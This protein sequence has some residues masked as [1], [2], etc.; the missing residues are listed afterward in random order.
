M[1]PVVSGTWRHPLVSMYSV[2]AAA[3][4]LV[5]VVSLVGIGALALTLPG[6]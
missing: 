2:I 5:V 1:F 3:V 6:C 4:V